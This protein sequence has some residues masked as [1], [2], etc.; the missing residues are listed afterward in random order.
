M[1]LHGEMHARCANVMRLL[2]YSMHSHTEQI[3]LPTRQRDDPRETIQRLVATS[4]LGRNAPS[5]SRDEERLR[6]RRFGLELGRKVLVNIIHYHR[7]SFITIVLPPCFSDA[8]RL[9][10]GDNC[11][12]SLGKDANSFGDYTK[13]P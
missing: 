9:R 11:D 1:K 4:T 2:S 12:D 6:F 5:P 13:S 8:E 7:D 3:C 10:I